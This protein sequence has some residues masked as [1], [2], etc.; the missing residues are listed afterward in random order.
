LVV[1]NLGTYFD[2]FFQ[3]K[4]ILISMGFVVFCCHFR[5]ISKAYQSIRLAIA[6]CLRALC[7]LEIQDTQ[8]VHLVLQ[9]HC[10]LC[11]V[12]K[13]LDRSEAAAVKDAT[14]HVVLPEP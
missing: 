6:L 5:Q 7:H 4:P 12:P 10:L 11:L 14:V 8:M 1:G 9:L 3:H 2:L 13:L